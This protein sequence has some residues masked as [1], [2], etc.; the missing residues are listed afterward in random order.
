MNRSCA[1]RR[2]GLL[3]LLA[4]LASPAVPAKNEPLKK[5][6]VE[7]LERRLAA[8]HGKR[9]AHAARELSAMELSERLSADRRARLLAGLP[10]VEARQALTALADLAEFLPLP[11]TEIPAAAPP[12][13]ATQNSLL[14]LAAESVEKAI[15]RLPNFF[16]T[17][18]TVLFA[19]DLADSSR[20]P[21]SA[22]QSRPIH[23]VD[24]ASATVL[25]RKGK[26]VAEPRGAASGRPARLGQELTIE[27]VFGPVLELVV[28]DVLKNGWTWSHWE[29]RAG[30]TLAVFSYSVPLRMS[31]YNVEIPGDQAGIYPLTAYHGEIAVDPA[32]GNILRLTMLADLSEFG[33]IARADVL[34]E[35]AP[36]A[37]GGKS[38]L[39]PVRSVAVSL[40]RPMDAL[41][42][43]YGF[44]RDE[45]EPMELELS[46]V[47]FREY[48]LF[49]SEARIVTGARG[50]AGQPPAPAAPDEPAAAPPQAPA[51]H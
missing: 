26:E 35:Y 24:S 6:T 33:P 37:I 25:Y 13:P 2:F 30:G 15:P 27:G 42:D 32:N 47:V 43:L 29:Q 22:S 36:I 9:N 7:Q 23:A 45:S 38:Y 11:A 8:L 20:S 44:R 19:E 1:I 14:S 3:L 51:A 21:S 46:D 41:R 31:H 49:R 28:A 39:C 18:D 4:A 5:V 48:H 12:D 50:D 10:D 40:A 16:A 17:R 34:V